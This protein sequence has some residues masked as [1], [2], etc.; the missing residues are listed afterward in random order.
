VAFV[1]ECSDDR[2]TMRV[3]V[4]LAVYESVRAEPRRFLVAP[5]HE[6]D[7]ERVVEQDAGYS[8]VEKLGGAGRISE[9]TDPRG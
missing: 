7:V 1:C 6:S 9:R 2:C 4:P 5:G 3:Q 8:I